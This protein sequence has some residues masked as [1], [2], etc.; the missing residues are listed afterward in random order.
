MRRATS[1]SSG[2]SLVVFALTPYG[3]LF[4]LLRSRVVRGGA[5][6][7]LLQRMGGRAHR[8]SAA[9]AAGRRARRPLAAGRLLARR[10]AALGR[11]RRPRRSRCRADDDPARAW[12]AGRARGPPRRRDRARPRR[13]A[14]TPSSSRSVA[15]AAGL[16]IENERL[17]AQLRAR[18]EELRASRA[19]LVEA[20]TAE[21]RRLERNLHDGAQQRLVAL[22]LT[23]AAR[24]GEAAQGPRRRRAAARPAPRRSSRWR[25]RSCASWRAASTRPC[26]RT[27]GSARRWR[28][29]PGARRSRSSSRPRRA[30]GCPRRSRPRPTS[31]SPRRSPTWSSTRTPRRRA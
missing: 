16:A 10:Q 22:S 1:A 18:V 30:S 21:R 8:P 6:S 26:S 3:F 15:A 12:Y 5:V 4:G 20:G 17:Q 13:C 9:R 31:S 23:H 14:T 29:S 19:R 28:R 2:L 27:A 24:P 7:E 11:R 25:S